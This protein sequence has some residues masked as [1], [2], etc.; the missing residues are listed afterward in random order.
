MK[1]K[2]WFSFLLT[3]VVT[4]S[5]LPISTWAAGSDSYTVPYTPGHTAK[6]PFDEFGDA[7]LGADEVIFQIDGLDK[8]SLCDLN[9]YN[10]LLE[11]TM[12]WD[13][14]ITAGTYSTT[15]TFVNTTTGKQ[16]VSRKV[17]LAVENDFIGSH[18]INQVIEGNWDSDIVL[19]FQNGTGSSRITAISKVSFFCMDGNDEVITPGFSF[20]EN[21][22]TYD[23][24]KGEIYIPKEHFQDRVLH[25]G[26]T[27]SSYV[28]IGTLDTF[29]L[30]NGEQISYA[31]VDDYPNYG[32]VPSEPIPNEEFVN[33]NRDFWYFMFTDNFFAGPFLGD[34][35]DDGSV[36]LSDT[37]LAVQFAVR[38]QDPTDKQR[39][40]ADLNNSGIIEFAD[41]IAIAKMAVQ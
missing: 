30:A 15:I 27:L 5:P 18:V 34:V 29:T 31:S 2:K 36:T 33:D 32:T 14:D 23:L 4:I 1:K 10:E 25:Y 3:A 16:T 39:Q 8:K 22:I 13:I 19:K 26:W 28:Y 12:P 21:N 40:R 35:T 7:W 6:I 24:E 11:I 20:F 9:H 38:I 17:K 41:V 37:L